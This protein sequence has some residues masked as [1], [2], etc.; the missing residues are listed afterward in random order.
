MLKVLLALTTYFVCVL[1]PAPSHALDV[2][3]TSAGIRAR[4]SSDRVLGKEYKAIR[5]GG[6]YRGMATP[7]G[8]TQD[9]VCDAEY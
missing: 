9:A 4:V 7:D 6:Y 5:G 1:A 3:L 8:L 2:D